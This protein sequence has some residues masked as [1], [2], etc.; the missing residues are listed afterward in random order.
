MWNATHSECKLYLLF[1]TEISNESNKFS[2]ESKNAVILFL[3]NVFNSRYRLS[4]VVSLI[5]VECFDIVI[6][7][8]E[9][10]TF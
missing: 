4:K 10:S 1:L 9:N 7:C 5:N 6:M 8:E 2:V 3:R